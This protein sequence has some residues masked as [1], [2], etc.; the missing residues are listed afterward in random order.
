MNN[1]DK[2][3]KFMKELNKALESTSKMQKIVKKQ[4]MQ[5]KGK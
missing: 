1:K 4:A 2:V 3:E 5:W